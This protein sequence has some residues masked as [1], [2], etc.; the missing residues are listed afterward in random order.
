[1]WCG[2]PEYDSLVQK[3]WADGVKGTKM[4]SIVQKLKRVKPA[5]KELN[6]TGFH[7]IGIQEAQAKAT[8]DSCQ[9]A[10]HS[11]PTDVSLIADEIATQ[12]VY[13]EK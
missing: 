13:R 12:K 7:E 11:N 10:L 6:N 4:Y 1:M 3:A 2:A 5:P 8:L 9:T